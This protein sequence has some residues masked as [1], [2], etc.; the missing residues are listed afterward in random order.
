MALTLPDS[1]DSGITLDDGDRW[2]QHCRVPLLHSAHTMTSRV[3]QDMK[4]VFEMDC[5]YPEAHAIS[6][7][8]EPAVIRLPHGISV[9]PDLPPRTRSVVG[10]AEQSERRPASAEPGAPPPRKKRRAPASEAVWRRR[11]EGANCRERRRMQRLNEAFDLLRHHL[12]QGSE[13]QL[14][15]HETL[16]MAMEYIS[17]LQLQLC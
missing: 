11:R 10:V 8:G 15:K 7:K 1:P 17:A 13:S 14:S 4:R 9:T 12:P 16:Q 6:V 2:M 5:S 3:K